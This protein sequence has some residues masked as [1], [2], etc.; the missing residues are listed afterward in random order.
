MLTFV[1]IVQ[2]TAST[3]LLTLIFLFSQHNLQ[4]TILKKGQQF[5]DIGVAAMDQKR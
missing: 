4:N 3:K 1:Y 2:P 5:S